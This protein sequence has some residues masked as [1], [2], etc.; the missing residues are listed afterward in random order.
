MVPRPAAASH[1]LLPVGFPELSIR[2]LGATLKLE[3]EAAAMGETLYL[4]S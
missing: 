3:A 2:L 1:L 4:L